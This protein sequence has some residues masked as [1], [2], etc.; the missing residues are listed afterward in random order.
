MPDTLRRAL[1]SMAGLTMV[2]AGCAPQS[3]PSTQDTI[4]TS[5]PA[6]ATELHIGLWTPLTL[7]GP[8]MVGA[9]GAEVMNAGLVNT[10]ERWTIQPYLAERVPSQ[11]DGTW[12]IRPDGTMQTTWTLRADAKWHDGAPVTAHDVEFAHHLYRDT[13]VQLD[14]NLP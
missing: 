5:A 12:V 13:D 10:D 7:F 4:V 1:M 11:D 6:K 14:T 2:I 9:R 8:R 3:A